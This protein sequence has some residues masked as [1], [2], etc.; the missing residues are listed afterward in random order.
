MLYFLGIYVSAFHEFLY[1]LFELSTNQSVAAILSMF[2]GKSDIKTVLMYA[3]YSVASRSRQQ[4]GA[5]I[6]TDDRSL[7]SKKWLSL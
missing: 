6:H 3:P 1:H 4:S 7:C 2:N 5:M